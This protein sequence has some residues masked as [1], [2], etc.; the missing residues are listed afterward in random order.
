VHC[1]CICKPD[2]GRAR[3][4]GRGVAEGAKDLSPSF[5]LRRRHKGVV[6]SRG[7][8]RN[9]NRLGSSSQLVRRHLRCFSRIL[10][11]KWLRPLRQGARKRSF[12]L[13]VQLLVDH[14]KRGRLQILAGPR[15]QHH[16]RSAGGGF[17]PRQHTSARNIDQA[18]RRK[19]SPEISDCFFC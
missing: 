19:D 11:C 4:A 2:L 1:S 14:Q 17:G 12:R 10:K 15:A 18:I 7:P 8:Q 13:Y 3:T 9:P 5:S 6:R 16:P